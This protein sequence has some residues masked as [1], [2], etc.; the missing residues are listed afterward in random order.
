[1]SASAPRNQGLSLTWTPADE[2]VVRRMKARPAA[3]HSSY[4]VGVQSQV[5]LLTL[6]EAALASD[7]V[8]LILV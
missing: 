4:D 6:T 1:L 7:G 2:C 5:W 3:S 8:H